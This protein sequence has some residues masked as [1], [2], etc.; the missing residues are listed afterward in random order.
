[1]K[2]S[3][4]L[5]LNT[6]LCHNITIVWG[7]Y[8]LPWYG[9]TSS[10]FILSHYQ[11]DFDYEY[12]SQICGGQNHNVS[13][14]SLILCLFH[15]APLNYWKSNDTRFQ[16]HGKITQ[17]LYC[18]WLVI[19]G[20]YLGKVTAVC[21]HFGIFVLSSDLNL[22]SIVSVDHITFRVFWLN[23]IL[24]RYRRD[25]GSIALRINFCVVFLNV[26]SA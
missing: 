11:L 14:I 5:S 8:S 4:K 23:I 18:L 21:K 2:F 22:P 9:N 6:K 17:F 26:W 16:T 10:L 13:Q 25:N 1:M 20:V 19:H 7:L 3:N 12:L 15:F 24:A